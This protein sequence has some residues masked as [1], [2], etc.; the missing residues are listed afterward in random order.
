V[1]VPNG[2][3]QNILAADWG[4]FEFID[5]HQRVFLAH[6][7][8]ADKEYEV[9]L[10]TAGG[11]YRYRTGDRV[12]CE[13]FTQEGPVLTFQGRGNLTSDLVGEKLTE[14]FVSRCLMPIRGFAMLTPRSEH[15][16][17]Y[18]LVVGEEKQQIS[19]TTKIEKSLCANPQYHYARRVGQLRPLAL[20]SLKQPEKVFQDHALKSGKKFGDI[21]IPAL[22][23]TPKW[24]ER[25]AVS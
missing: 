16:A 13:G 23:L 22:T 11:L 9:I 5:D 4:F 14:A 7:L 2:Q 21:K 25:E 12:R 19:I 3:G 10:S 6:D 24:W 17:G 18:D 8:G 1:T 20:V 15:R